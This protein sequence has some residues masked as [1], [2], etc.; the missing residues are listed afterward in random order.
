M[1]KILL[2]A[3]VVL[4]GCSSQASRMANCE[5]QGVS[6]DACYIAEQNRQASIVNAAEKQALVNAQHAQSVHKS[7]VLHKH[8]EGMEIKRDSSGLVYVDGKPAAKTEA[9]PTGGESWQQGLHDFVIYPNGK[10][11]VLKDGIFEGYAK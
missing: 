7:K 8:Y 3:V 4:S 2:L 1:K 10:V 6:K 11:A 9:S 5:A